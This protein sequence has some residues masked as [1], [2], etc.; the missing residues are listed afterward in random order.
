M[1]NSIGRQLNRFGLGLKSNWPLLSFVLVLIAYS[2]LFLD[3][4]Q[5][6][7]FFLLSAFCLI[8]NAFLLSRSFVF[9]FSKKV[10][11]FFSIYLIYL[12]SGISGLFTGLD[13]YTALYEL[14]KLFLYLNFAILI[15]VFFQDR[16]ALAFRVGICFSIVQFIA[17]LAIIYTDINNPYLSIFSASKLYGG[18][19]I[20]PNLNS[21]ILFLTLPM[22]LYAFFSAK[23]KALRF[24]LGLL[25]LAN[26]F[27]IYWLKSWTV[28][29]AICIGVLAFGL[30]YFMS[31]KRVPYWLKRFGFLF[32]GALISYAFFTVKPFEMGKRSLKHRQLLW[33]RTVE[34]IKQKPILGSGIASWSVENVNYAHSEDEVKRRSNEGVY[35]PS[36]AIFYERPHNDF[37]WIWSEQGLIGLIS[38]LALFF[39]ALYMG[40]SRFFHSTGS[41]KK[42]YGLIS[43]AIFSYLFIACFSFPKERI[44][45]SLILMLYFSLL[46]ID[47]KDSKEQSMLSGHKR[48]FVVFL[49]IISSGSC[50]VA[51]NRAVSDYYM[52]NIIEAKRQ[53]NW[54]SVIRDGQKGESVFY[55]KASNGTPFQW[56]MGLARMEQGDLARAHQNFREAYKFHPT[57]LYVLNNLG[58]TYSLLEKRDSSFIFYNRA[59]ELNPIYED[60]MINKSS[61]FFNEGKLDSAWLTISKI[62]AGS[63]NKRYPLFIQTILYAKHADGIREEAIKRGVFEAADSLLNQQSKVPLFLDLYRKSQKVNTSIKSEFFKRLGVEKEI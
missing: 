14:L 41:E 34:M 56:Y 63:I 31:E 4:G 3:P 25:C 40:L 45:Q 8:G 27:F 28:Y 47:F 32:L 15:Y 7:K 51:Y 60:P 38:Y 16:K 17:I 43:L 19:Y 23:S 30:L 35:T 50:V 11:W 21:Q 6:L 24:A 54:Y 36:G 57:H 55:P 48:L 18:L 26:L 1:E 42:K 13:F 22:V 29:M 12:L 61:I 59:L 2:T 44:D 46:L 39:F 58:S 52:R 62:P 10:K 37:L 5:P 33:E 53:N 20:N 9:S 49:L